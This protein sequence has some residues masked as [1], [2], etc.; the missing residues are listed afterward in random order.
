[1][2]LE[3]DPERKDD[4]HPEP[5]ARSEEA[6][7]SRKSEKIGPLRRHSLPQLNRA[8]EQLE[9]EHQRAHPHGDVH[10]HALNHV[11][12]VHRPQPARDQIAR[13]DH[14][15]NQRAQFERD[16]IARRDREDVAEARRLDLNV[17]DREHDRDDG[18]RH[19]NPVRLVEIGQH[20]RGRDVAERLA[21]RP[22]PAPEHVGDPADEH[23]PRARGP[24]PDPVRVEEP[25][26]T[27]EGE[28]GVVGGDDRQV[29]DDEPGLPPVQK[30]VLQVHRHAPVRDGPQHDRGQ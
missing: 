24:E 14:E 30:E 18:R 8:A 5:H 26:R 1:M 23:R 25:A 27:E 6:L 4:D 13:R 10:P 11:C 21:E 2:R 20:I 15:Q 19:P 7:R 17:E 16:P 9:G 22:D 3:D 28:R 29:E 12:P